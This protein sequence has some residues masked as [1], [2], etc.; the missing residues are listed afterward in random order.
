MKKTLVV[1]KEGNT[2]T[3]ELYDNNLIYKFMVWHSSFGFTRKEYL[4]NLLDVDRFNKL[5]ES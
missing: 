4:L 5:M 3:I 2:Y 1:K